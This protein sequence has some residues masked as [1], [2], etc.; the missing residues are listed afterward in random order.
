VQALLVTKGTYPVYQCGE[1][2]LL[3]GRMVVRVG[4]ELEVSVRGFA[5][6]LMAQ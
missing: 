3:V 6:D 5:V 2:S 4:V 1:Y